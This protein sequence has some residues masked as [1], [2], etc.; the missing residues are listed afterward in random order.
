ML[1]RT[2]KRYAAYFRGWCQTFGEHES[3][4]DHE[5]DI[6]WLLAGHQ[7]GFVLPPAYLKRLHRA[8]LL[9][10]VPPALTFRRFQV[11]V[12]E[13]S[14]SLTPRREELIRETIRQMLADDAPLHVYL[15][16][17]FMYGTRARIVTLS[18]NKPISIIYK[19]IGRMPIRLD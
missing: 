18:T 15:T 8:V 11:E 6:F 7:A 5:N 1:E 10:K 19:E 17:H 9:H 13:F 16:S 3:F 2:V 14:F 12:G 4:A